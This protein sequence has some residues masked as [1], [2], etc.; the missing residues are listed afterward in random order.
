LQRLPQGVKFTLEIYKTLYSA[1][2]K[3]ALLLKPKMLKLNIKRELFLR[4]AADI[5]LRLRLP[6]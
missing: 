3:T 5:I 2:R 4:L 1:Q 6:N